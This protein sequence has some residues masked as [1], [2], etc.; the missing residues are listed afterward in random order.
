MRTIGQIKFK[1]ALNQLEE[2]GV[3]ENIILISAA[4]LRILGFRVYTHFIDLLV[5]QSYYIQK[6][7]ESNFLPKYELEPIPITIVDFSMRIGTVENGLCSFRHMIEPYEV[8]QEVEFKLDNEVK[9][10]KIRPHTY[11]R[12]DCEEAIGRLLQ[13]SNVKYWQD[14][15]SYHKQIEA[16][17][18]G[19]SRDKLKFG[20]QKYLKFEE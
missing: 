4:S 7:K 1:K 12:K 11:V 2:D 14:L 19:M 9:L 10:L 17:D 15:Y 13:G 16:I 20:P 18:L 5:Q 6:A 3:L 8:Y